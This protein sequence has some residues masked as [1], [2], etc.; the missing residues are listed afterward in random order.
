MILYGIVLIFNFLLLVLQIR[1]HLCITHNIL[2]FALEMKPQ[3]PK[4]T[5]EQ[6]DGSTIYATSKQLLFCK[7][8][9]AKHNKPFRRSGA[10][11]LTRY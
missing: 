7:S 3:L 2:H 1:V 5:T 4:Y 10:R 9:G 11:G 8:P 6:T